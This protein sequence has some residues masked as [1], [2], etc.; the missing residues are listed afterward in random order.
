M[1]FSCYFYLKDLHGTSNQQDMRV[2]QCFQLKAVSVIY[3]HTVAAGQYS[4]VHF[5]FTFDHEDIHSC[6]RLVHVVS[7]LFA[8]FYLSDGEP[9]LLQHLGRSVTVAVKQST[10]V[11]SCAEGTDVI[12]LIGGRGIQLFGYYPDLEKLCRF[13]ITSIHFAVV[14]AR[15][16]THGLDVAWA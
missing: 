4:V 1:A 2:F 11:R 9:C 6:M 16:C 7:D 3:T 14:D 15:A 13:G 12:I 8:C 10:P 5:H